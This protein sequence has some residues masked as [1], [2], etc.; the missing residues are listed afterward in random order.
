MI[1]CATSRLADRAAK[2]PLQG[3]GGGW[4]APTTCRGQAIFSPTKKQTIDKTQWT[5]AAGWTFSAPVAIC[6]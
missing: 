2:I 5:V 4:G 3:P 1:R 6:Y